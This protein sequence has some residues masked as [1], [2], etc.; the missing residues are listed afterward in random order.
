MLTRRVYVVCVVRRWCRLK[1][2]RCL[3]LDIRHSVHHKLLI[4]RKKLE[5]D[6]DDADCNYNM[7]LEILGKY[8]NCKATTYRTLLFERRIVF[9]FDDLYIL[10]FAARVFIIPDSEKLLATV[11]HN[12]FVRYKHRT[13]LI[14]WIFW[15]IS[16]PLCVV[17]NGCL[18]YFF[19]YFLKGLAR[20]ASGFCVKRIL[21]LL[22]QSIREESCR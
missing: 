12:N 4:R 13:N 10:S 20:I 5:I 11:Y 3:A 16:T 18:L 6:K 22:R 14:F 19:W 8:E 21:R 2:T 17:Y 9:I 7:I 1:T 15:L